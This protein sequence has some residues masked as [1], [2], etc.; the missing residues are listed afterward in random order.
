MTITISQLQFIKYERLK[1]QKVDVPVAQFKQEKAVTL[2]SSVF[3][4]YFEEENV[5]KVFMGK[6][7]EAEYLAYLRADGR[8]ILRRVLKKKD[9]G[10]D[11]INRPL[12]KSKWG[13][14]LKS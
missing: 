9:K 1:V 8:I 12:D 11:W 4:F 3:P 13:L 7:E 10:V 6:S 5:Y 2:A 14:L